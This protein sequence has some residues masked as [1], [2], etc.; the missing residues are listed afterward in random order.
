MF[1][2]VSDSD[3]EDWTSWHWDNLRIRMRW[4]ECRLSHRLHIC[5]EVILWRYLAA[6]VWT[7]SSCV[8]YVTLCYARQFNATAV[9]AIARTALIL[10]LTWHVP[11]ARE[12]GLKKNYRQIKLTIRLFS[13]Y[14][15]IRLF[16][17]SAYMNECT[18]GPSAMAELHVLI[19]L[20]AS[21]AELPM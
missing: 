19:F 11:L 12:K 13:D 6:L 18:R 2:L 16:T 17:P 15:F 9:I 14:C 21:T 7:R 20:Q 1:C 8:L 10:L 3:A 4:Q 5:E